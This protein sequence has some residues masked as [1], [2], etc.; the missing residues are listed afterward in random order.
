GCLGEWIVSSDS[1]APGLGK[2]D[3]FEDERVVARGHPRESHLVWRDV[4]NR[5]SRHICTLVV[6]GRRLGQHTKTAA[7]SDALHL[8]FNTAGPDEGWTSSITQLRCDISPFGHRLRV[9]QQ[10]L[11]GE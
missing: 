10:M 6:H 7:C 5:H 3:E 8:L 11:V 1:S 2:L 4:S 9:L